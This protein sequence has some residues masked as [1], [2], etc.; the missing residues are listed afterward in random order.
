MT[1]HL[2]M[3]LSKKTVRFLL[4][5]MLS[6]VLLLAACNKNPGGPSDNPGDI[7][8][9]ESNQYGSNE[10]AILAYYN[11]GTGKLSPLPGS[12][13]KTGG[14][15]IGNPQQILGPDDQETPLAFSANKK[16]LF[17][18]NAGSNTIAAFSIDDQ[19]RLQTVPG[20]PFSSG[21][22]TPQSVAVSG[23]YLYVAN[24]AQDP[25]HG[26]TRIPN[27]NVL[28]IGGNGSLTQVPHGVFETSVGASP[29]QV[30]VSGNKKFLFTSDFLGFMEKIPA[31]TL[32]SFTIGSNGLLTAVAGSPYFI[33]GA[34]GALGLWQHPAADVL[35]VGFP[36]QGKVGVYTINNANGALSFQEMVDAG[37]AA[38]WIRTN[39]TGSRMYTLNS[40]ENTISIFNTSSAAAPSALQ[41]FPMK[42]PG[43]LVGANNSATSQ[44]F[45]LGFSKADKFLYVVNQHTSTDFS[46]GNFNYLHVLTVAADGQ[47]SEPTEPLQLPVSNMVR[48][49]GIAVY[50]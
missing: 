38:C 49:Q 42:I 6:F 24:K 40:G 12:P 7:V 10:N 23:D 43:P 18:V 11:D 1:Q 47:L 4:P 39:S 31:G 37:P 34:G 30:L 15:G 28:K 17:A 19:G 22:E 41:K 33:P 5:G 44:P 46:N 25:I 13:F 27:Y 3:P 36:V 35:Y 50:Y 21:G 9:L 14:A 16:Y 2:S 32:R 48:P 45:G 26:N 8:Y 29:S 20:S